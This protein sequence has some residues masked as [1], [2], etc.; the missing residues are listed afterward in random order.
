MFSC[1]SVSVGSPSRGP[2]T[3]HYTFSNVTS[4][5][6]I[7]A[8]LKMIRYNDIEKLVIFLDS[9]TVPGVPL[10]RKK[11][12]SEYNILTKRYEVA[13][14]HLFFFPLKPPRANIRIT[15][16]EVSHKNVINYVS[17]SLKNRNKRH[18]SSISSAIFFDVFQ[19]FLCLTL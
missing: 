5:L 2:S 18:S 14:N 15:Y 4:K 1:T 3:T 16:P 17:H 10:Y 12:I 6:V 8:S 19:A 7:Y 13:T 9:S 11:N